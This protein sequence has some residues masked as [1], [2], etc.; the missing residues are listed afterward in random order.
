MSGIVPITMGGLLSALERASSG[1]ELQRV[2]FAFGSAVPTVIDSWRG[3][4]SEPA[5]GYELGGVRLLSDLTDEIRSAIGQV[6]SGY[7]GGNYT[8]RADQHVRVDNPGECNVSVLIGVEWG[9]STVLLH[10]AGDLDW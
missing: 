4:Y 8:M 2:Q 5:L 6:Y 9:E 7:K 3:I 1:D 10:T